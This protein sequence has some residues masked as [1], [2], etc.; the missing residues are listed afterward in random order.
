[1]TAE[2]PGR[3]H[4]LLLY[5]RTMDRVWG[6]SLFGG[7]FIVGWL[8]AAWFG[9]LAPLAPIPNVIAI[10]GAV[11]LIGFSLFALLA[12][13]MSYVQAQSNHI[14]VVTPFL[15][16]KIG[17]SRIKSIRPAQFASLFPPTSTSWGTRHFLEPFYAKTALIIDLN[18]LPVSRGFLRLFLASQMFLP[19][20]NSLVILVK[21]W[22]VLSTEMESR[23]HSKKQ[24]YSTQKPGGYGLLQDIHKK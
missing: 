8:T 11:L 22:M 15:R 23:K 20:T 17:Y 14:R 12:R 13:G 3:R 19:K 7:L 18:S 10:G 9:W 1:M 24:V 5:Y 6:V 16:L 4:R 21:D 2:K